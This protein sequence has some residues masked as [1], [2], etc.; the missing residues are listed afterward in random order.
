M[1]LADVK[2]WFP[3]AQ[4][5]LDENM[6]EAVV[7]EAEKVLEPFRTSNDAVEFRVPVHIITATRS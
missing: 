5:N 2:G 3:F 7:N 1:V 6:I 4:I